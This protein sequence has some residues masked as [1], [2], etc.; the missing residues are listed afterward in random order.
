MH[1]I[2]TKSLFKTLT[3]YLDIY[4]PLFYKRS[5]NK[6]LIF[7][8]SILAVQEIRS[9]KFIYE[10][11]IKKYFDGCL[12]SFYYFLADENL[13][14]SKMAICTVS[15]ALSLLQPC[16]KDK[17]TVYLMVDDTLQPKFGKKF[18]CCRTLFDHADHSGT[19][20]KN[21]HCFV[22]LAM[23]LPLLVN[24][25]IKYV[26]IPIN[27]KL[28]D[29]SKTKLE[30]AAKLIEEI[31]PPLKDYQVI[32]LCDAWYTKKPFLSRILA[33][34]FVELIGAARVDT[35]TYELPPA[36]T[37]KKGR[38]RKKGDRIDYKTLS[39]SEEG[40]SEN[41]FQ[42][43][44]QCLTNL[45]ERVVCATYTTTQTTSFGSVRLYLSTIPLEAL[46]SF[47]VKET[48]GL[49]LEKKPILSNVFSVYRMRWSIE[50]MFY[51]EKTF[52]SF[53]KYMVRSKVGIEKYAHLVGVTYTLTILLPFLDSNFSEYQFQSPQEIKYSFGAKLYEELIMGNLL[54]T[55]QLRKNIEAFSAL[56]EYLNSE[57]IAS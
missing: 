1:S 21:G 26:N 29:K 13:N 43:T 35:V 14:L 56:Q 24:G 11:F 53:G 23:G 30:L 3:E 37:G 51:Q 4:K 49:D 52:W 40:S 8:C 22:S 39:F 44:V 32:V 27:C 6:F 12:N 20:Y 36:L 48:Q 46:R 18:E 41:L 33:F 19:P 9:I 54:K 15:K 16:V 5:F 10:K 34:D 57:D 25:Y 47:A 28:Y 55:L 50:V 45:T 2:Y 42:S 38:P 31:I 7:I 17:V